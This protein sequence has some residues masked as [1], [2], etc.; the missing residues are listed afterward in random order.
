MNENLSNLSEAAV[1]LRAARDVLVF[2]GAGVSAESG[3]ATFRDDGGFW[4]RFPPEEFATW[5]GLTKT[6]AA[7]PGELAEFLLALLEPIAQ[8][9]PNPGHRAIAELEKHTRVTVVT[10]NVDRL[11]QEAGSTAVHEIHGSL[12]EVVAKDGRPL[13]TLTR[14]D[15]RAI[16]EGLQRARASR[17]TLPRMLWSVQPLFGLGA[18]LLHRPRIVLFGDGMAEPDW[19]QAREAVQR[20]EVMLVV[21]TSELVYPAA[22]LPHDAKAAGAK[23][24]RIDPEPG[25]ADLWLSG[26]AGK[27]LPALL[28]EAFEAASS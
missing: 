23:V 1:W 21:G 13:R 15:L 11:H 19:S 20:C 25:T 6:A 14:S 12:F 3:I 2:T 10:Q 26:T 8:A 27:V 18:G 24:I 16:I 9:A 28:R 17:L 4:N 5:S 22:M 7:R